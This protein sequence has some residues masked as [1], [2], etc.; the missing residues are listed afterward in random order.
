MLIKQ[1]I[2]VFGISVLQASAKIIR[3]ELFRPTESPNANQSLDEG[4]T[5]TC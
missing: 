4:V 5:R 1:Q 2:T 3:S